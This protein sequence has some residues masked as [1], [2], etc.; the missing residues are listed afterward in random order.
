MARAEQAFD[1]RFVD[2]AVNGI[3][4]LTESAGGHLRTLQT[5]SVRQ[6]V[7]LLGVGL[8]SA[9]AVVFTFLAA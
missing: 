5:G 8:L 3:A 6:Y 2:G 9:F 1:G 4:R 7:M